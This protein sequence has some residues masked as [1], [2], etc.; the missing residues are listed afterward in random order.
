MA[1][2]MVFDSLIRHL[3]FRN[4]FMKNINEGLELLKKT[5]NI[6]GS[7]VTYRVLTALGLF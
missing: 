2:D 1:K 7:G 6:A 4:I 5:D 3:V